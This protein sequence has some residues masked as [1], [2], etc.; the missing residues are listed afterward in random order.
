M[1]DYFRR[2]LYRFKA[3]RHNRAL[4]ANRRAI[5]KAREEWRRRDKPVEDDDTLP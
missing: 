2:L 1:L 5:D 3:W 4:R